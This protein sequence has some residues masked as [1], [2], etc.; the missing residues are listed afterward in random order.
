M[1]QEFIPGG[2]VGLSMLIR[3][4]DV[5]LAFQH[6]RIREF[7]PQGGV[8][9][10]CVS[11]PLNAEL[12][13]HS[14][15]L[16]L[17]MDWE[18]VAMVEYRVDEGTGRYAL[19]EVNGRFWGSLPAAIHAGAQ[20]PFWLYRTSFPDAPNP[21]QSYRTGLVA[22]SLAGDS[23]WLWSTVRARPAGA[24]RA[25]AAYLGAFRPSIRYFIWAWDDPRPAIHNLMCRFRRVN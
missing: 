16:L 14:R 12:L 8:S 13:E 23:K 1:V 7:P 4:R 22:R 6:R 21:E 24:P 17:E 18:G 11:E 15:R 19:M 2:G 3:R 5:A 25:L 10:A 9:V 20:F